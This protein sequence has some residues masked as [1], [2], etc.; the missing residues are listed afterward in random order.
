MNQVSLSLILIM[1][2]VRIIKMFLKMLKVKMSILTL[3]VTEQNK[4]ILYFVFTNKY[5]F[6]FSIG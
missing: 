3:S 1:K 4:V 5:T 2:I 6:M